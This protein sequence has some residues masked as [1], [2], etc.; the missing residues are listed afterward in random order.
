MVENQTGER[1]QKVIDG[2]TEDDD[3]QVT[4]G[5]KIKKLRSDNGKEYLSNDFIKFCKDHGQLELQRG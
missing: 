2:I 5:N 4:D 3:A 1:I